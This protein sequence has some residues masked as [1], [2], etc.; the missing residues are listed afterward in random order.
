MVDKVH[1][2]LMSGEI[3]FGVGVHCCDDFLFVS[4]EMMK[5]Q[6]RRF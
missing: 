1:R 3:A 5:N 6:G 4:I 2:R